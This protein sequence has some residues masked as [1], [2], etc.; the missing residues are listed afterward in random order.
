MS[1]N[2]KID[3]SQLKNMIQILGQYSLRLSRSSKSGKGRKSILRESRDDMM[4]KY[5][6]VSWMRF[7][8]RKRAVGKH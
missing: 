5:N 3:K 7:S 1:N 6:M 2:E 4:V 8:N